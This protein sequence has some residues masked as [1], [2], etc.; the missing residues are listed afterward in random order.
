MENA[1][2]ALLIAAAVLI[3]IVLIAVGIRILSSTSG[4]VDQVESLS[5]TM[6]TSIF[7]SQYTQYDGKQTGTAVKKLINQA[8]T[9]NAT[10]TDTNKKIKISTVLDTSKGLKTHTNAYADETVNTILSEINVNYTYTVTV[11][12]SSTTGLV[13]GIKIQ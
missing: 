10:V 5:T 13:N 11:S 12:I 1:T 6:E 3:A 7:N 2:K 9:Y 4:T 8:K